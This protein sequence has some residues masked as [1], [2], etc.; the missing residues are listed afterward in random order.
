MGA[1]HDDR[2]QFLE[3]MDLMIE[4]NEIPNESYVPE[5]VDR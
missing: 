1:V 5:V 4:H 2:F 3:N